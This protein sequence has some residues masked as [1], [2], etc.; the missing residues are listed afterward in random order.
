MATKEIQIPV[1]LDPPTHRKL[2][3]AA[4]RDN[5]SVNGQLRVLIDEYVSKGK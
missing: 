4:K 1:R 2:K 5:R 3:A